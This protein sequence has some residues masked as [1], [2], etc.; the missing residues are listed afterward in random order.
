MVLCPA[1]T[2]EQH[3][4]LGPDRRARPRRRRAA[5][6]AAQAKAAG[7]PTPVYH[8]AAPG[9]EGL[10]RAITKAHRA[11]ATS[12]QNA[13]QLED[14]SAQASSATAPQAASGVRAG[15]AHRPGRA[16]DAEGLDGTHPA[17][18]TP[19]PP[20]K[21]VTAAK[22]VA[23]ATAASR[24][25][26]ACRRA[27]NGAEA[28]QGR[29]DPVLEPQGTRRPGGARELQRGSA[30]RSAGSIACHKTRAAQRRSA[31]FGSITRAVQVYQTPTILIVN[32]KGQTTDATA[33][34]TPSRSNRHRRSSRHRVGR[35]D[36]EPRCTTLADERPWSIISKPARARALPRGRVHGRRGRGRV[37]RSDPDLARDRSRRARR[38]HRG[39]GLRRERMRRDRRGGQRHRGPAARRSAA[40]RGADRRAEIAAELGGLSV[41]KRH[42]AELAADALHRALGG[43][44]AGARRAGPGGRAHAGRDERRRGQRGRGAARGAERRAR[45]SASR[46]NCGLTRRTTASA[47]AARRRRSA[48]HASWRT[49]WACRTCR[50]TCAQ[51]SAPAWSTTGSPTTPPA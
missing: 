31:S 29:R 24:G 42:A 7:A 35:Y 32:K 6:A 9:V 8:G 40:W 26:R 13:K 37:R 15:R 18:S 33:S 46:S 45:R 27:W 17:T 39:R 36:L 23:G 20:R 51:S 4:R 5:S 21:T 16:T 48:A 14:K 12:Q 25:A 34:T 43:A 1:G 50:S 49:G 41:A 19:R 30:T 2:L 10:S 3:E 11:V 47:A 38:A 44:A 22:Q 28:G